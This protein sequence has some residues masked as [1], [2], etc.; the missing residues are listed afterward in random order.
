MA[1]TPPTGR[2]VM[3][4]WCCIALALGVALRRSPVLTGAPVQG[5]GFQ[6]VVGAPSVAF[7][8]LILVI[9]LAVRETLRWKRRRTAQSAQESSGTTLA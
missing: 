2:H 3:L 6:A 1:I 4:L 9:L 8:P 7:V 5:D